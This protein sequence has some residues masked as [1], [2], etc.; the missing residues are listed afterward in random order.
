VR[1]L[2][3]VK[4]SI[5]AGLLVGLG[6][7]IPLARGDAKPA[8]IST[9]E[10]KDG[11]KGYGLTVFRGT[12]PEKFDV[13]VVS[14]LH[15]FRP[16]QDLIL[17]KTPHPR[18][19]IT[20][21]VRGMSG[22]PIYLDGR[23][24]G[25]Y[26]YSLAMFQV[27]PV[28][29]VTPIAPML[30]ELHRP[31]PPGF[32]PLEG[33][34]PLPHGSPP[35]AG[36]RSPHDKHATLTP[37]SFDG[38]PGEYNL[39]EHAKMLASRF[40]GVDP[41]R[42]II[43]T[44]TPVMLGGVGDRTAEYMR[45][46][47]EP[48]GLEPLQAGGG[49]MP[50]DP[51][52]PMHFVDGGSLG[53]SF[54][55]GDV[56]FFGLGTVTHVEGTRACGFGHPMMEAGNMAFPTAIARVLWIYASDQH[57]MKVGESIRPLGA[58][59]QDRQSAV[60]VDETKTAPTFPIHVE[61]KG[62][63]GAPKTTW[64]A[65][66][67]ED[68]F[69]APG[70]A[71]AVM[72]SAIE[73]TANERR[74]CTWKLTSKLKVRGHGEI[75]LEDFGVAIGGMVDA[76][77]LSVSRIIHALG[78]VVNNPWEDVHIDGI[79]SVLTVDYTR[80]L[81]RMRG[82]EL[83]DPVVDA[84]QKARV[85][86]KLFPLHGPDVERVLEFAVPEELAGKDVEV[87]IAPGYAVA[88]DVASPESLNDL[89]ANETRQSLLPRSL[90]TQMKVAQGVVYHQHVAERL[91]SFAMDALRPT[92][93]NTGPDAITSYARAVFPLDRYVEGH[94]KVKIKVRPVVR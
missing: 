2:V 33:G 43:P 14:V 1:K 87:E 58:L 85:R 92:G 54:A 50:Q 74:D 18:L 32:W 48:M 80:D 46:L 36:A 13:E 67:A 83:L 70:I 6:T 40:S 16:A 10:I 71:S 60:V 15:N 88:Q 25:A 7:S 29:G 64:D 44:A 8:T 69:I 53:V 35:P 51:N 57:S 61:V 91:P 75:A 4:A 24:A 59:V 11:M 72:G 5:A 49:G 63:V 38:A 34:G 19:N 52:A 81:Y 78:D 22:S 68:K 47:F 3:V 20:K 30:T 56:S 89:L 9:A 41:T 55:R 86:V 65:V 26:A 77:E 62:V 82:V 45:K 42:P 12:E 37:T 66:V 94:D 21:N 79:E 39:D 93:S 17:V 31:I 76:G 84:G 27:E 73:A 23:L 28:A 90:V